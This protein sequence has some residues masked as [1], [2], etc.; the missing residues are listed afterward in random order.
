MIILRIV[1]FTLG[2]RGDVQPYIA[3][4]KYAISRG[5][6]VRICSGNSFKSLIEDH[7]VEFKEIESDLM[8]MLNTEEGQR[9]YNEGI[10]HFLKAKRYLKEVVNPKYR[11]SLNQFWEAAKDANI[12]LYHPKAFG[13]PDMAKALGIKCI[14]MPTV[15]IT[16]PIDEFP[17]LII[18]P[19]KNFGKRI[20]RLTYKLVEKSEISSIK[21]INDFRRKVLGLENRKSG[22]YTFDIDN[23]HIPIIYPISPYLFKDVKS[24]NKKVYLSGF[25]YLK[26]KDDLNDEIKKFIDKGPTPVVVSFSSLPLKKPD[27]FKN[28]LLEALK[29][30]NNRCIL[31]KGNMDIEIDDENILLIKEAPHEKI[32]PLCKGIIHHG[33]VGTMATALISGKPQLIIPF[34]ADQP[35]WASLLYKNGYTIK[36]IKEKDI[37]SKTLEHSLRQMEDI[38]TIKKAKEIKGIIERENGVHNA[39]KYIEKIYFT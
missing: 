27:I 23:K 36:P 14:S 8:A 10:K 28:E 4:A 30:T 33:G 25:L 22:I 20:N 29:K 11:K 1:I 17:N 35:F 7:G 16:Y 37:S 2:T 3:L 26:L 38:E 19:T 15:P 32:F 18:S 6:K 24:W 9:I 31:L 39:V 12:I 21:E 5:H 34:S 13:A